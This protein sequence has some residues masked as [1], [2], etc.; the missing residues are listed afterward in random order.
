[1]AKRVFLIF[2][3]KALYKN[4]RTCLVTDKCFSVFQICEHLFVEHFCRLCYAKYETKVKK[5]LH[6]PP[7]KNQKKIS[8]YRNYKAIL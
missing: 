8:I 1:M 6:T 3:K 2:F 4:C 7:K 5:T